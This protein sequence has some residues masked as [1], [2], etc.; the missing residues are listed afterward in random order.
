MQIKLYDALLP[1]LP[2]EVVTLIVHYSYPKGPDLA[3]LEKISRA[4]HEFISTNDILWK[5][6]FKRDFYYDLS[7]SLDR[8]SQYIERYKRPYNY[9]RTLPTK[10]LH[11][12]DNENALRFVP[13]KN[14]VVGV[15][16]T[17]LTVFDG[18]N[19]SPRFQITKFPVSEWF[20]EFDDAPIVPGDFLRV[21]LINSTTL[22]CI[23]NNNFGIWNLKNGECYFAKSL[24]HLRLIDFNEKKIIYLDDDNNFKIHEG[25][26]WKPVKKI[27]APLNTANITAKL[28]GD[29]YLVLVNQKILYVYDLFKKDCL[30]Q[31]T[32]K[33][34]I[35]NEF[36]L[37]SEKKIV[38]LYPRSADKPHEVQIYNLQMR[39]IDTS[40]LNLFAF[41]F[42]NDRIFGLYNHENKWIIAFFDVK[43]TLFH[44]VQFPEIKLN[45]FWQFFS[46]GPHLG[47]IQD[48]SIYFWN[49]VT[50]TYLLSRRF[51]FLNKNI[52][53]LCIDGNILYLLKGRDRLYFYDLASLRSLSRGEGPKI[54]HA[55]FSVLD[56]KIMT[57]F[58]ERTLSEN[59][60][61]SFDAVLE[62]IDYKNPLITMIG[63]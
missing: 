63:K 25:Q 4:W 48:K 41:R 6:V 9:A 15:Y 29:I 2:D 19:G 34:P 55:Q 33:I 59:S 43:T 52:K 51:C 61:R 11:L 16:S 17:H 40:F 38:I 46:G 30:C 13:G 58:K 8:K 21:Q 35:H 49:M 20:R 42:E 1:G 24:Q 47:I 26:G 57:C 54:N 62:F 39:L 7:I 22:V 37:T 27:K 5:E 18:E 44:Y 28:F 60:S 23:Q 32:L 14:V 3:K 45:R 53:F 12:C 36:W 31:L 50:H 56:G 10:K